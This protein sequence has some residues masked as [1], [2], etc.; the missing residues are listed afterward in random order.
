VLVTAALVSAASGVG[1]AAPPTS[2][3][4]RELVGQ[5]MVVALEGTSPGGAL[6]RRIEDGEVGGVVLFGGNV[7][8]RAQVRALTAALHAAA[9]RGG[10][11]RLLVMVDQEGG[12]VRRFRWLPPG[13]SAAQLGRRPL[14]AVRASGSG[15]GRALRALGVDVDL[16][17]VADVPRVDGSFLTAQER[18]FSSSADV[19]AAHAAAF[20]RGLA[21][22]GILATAKHF[23]GLGGAVEN[24]D[25]SPVTIAG[26]A[27]ALEDD[28]LPFRRLVAADVPLVMLSSAAYRAYGGR[29]AVWSPG[30][31]A[32][33]RD[34]LGF[35]GVTVSDALEPLARLR[36]VALGAAALRAALA[37]TDLLLFAGPAATSARAYASLVA[38]AGQGRLSRAS[39]RESYDRVMALKR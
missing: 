20:G 16:A 26:G 32:L 19:A 21:A 1:R 7:R 10:R 27:A 12:A 30:V 34:G 11:S 31:H 8:S 36:R 35:A 23:P 33:L 13:L 18:A 4:L 5:R 24:T 15:T 28:L 6:V 2:P 29:P 25:L 3:T 37:G 17:P 39:L 22:A 14:A 9:R 38:A